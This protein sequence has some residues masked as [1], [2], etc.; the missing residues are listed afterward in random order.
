MSARDTFEFTTNKTWDDTAEVAPDA[1]RDVLVVGDIHGTK[2]H[3]A[4]AITHAADLGAQAIVQVGDFWL[5]DRHWSRF[6]PL[7]AEYMQA[8]CDSPLPIVVIDGNHEIWPA[9]GRYALTP[10]AR[11]AMQERRPLHL[12]GSLWW[13]WRGSVWRWNDCAFGALGGAVSPDKRLPEVRHY[14]WLEEALDE[15]DVDR[16][17]VNTEAEFDGRLD[18]LFT[19]DAP[20]QVIGLKSGMT[21]IP[22][23]VLREAKHGRRLL[24]HAV[25]RTQP[26]L[27]LHG[28]WHQANAERISGRTEVIGLAEDGRQNH[29][30][31]LSTQPTLVAV[32]A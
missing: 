28:H 24:A 30:A 13:A 8:A 11:A 29:T 32:Y 26:E 9:L 17:I 16:L 4:D 6:S 14:R 3:L 18:V 25:D 21:G 31:L 15:D 19:H 10:A 5:A 2:T 22:F 20:A 1:V 7:Q 23:D 12:G 27:V